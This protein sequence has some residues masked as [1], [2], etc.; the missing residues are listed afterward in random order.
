M[1]LVPPSWLFRVITSL[2]SLVLYQLRSLC[3]GSGNR[4]MCIIMKLDWLLLCSTWS[5]TEGC[6]SPVVGII[7]AGSSYCWKPLVE[8]YFNTASV[9][10]SFDFALQSASI[11][12]FPR[13]PMVRMIKS[14]EV[15][16]KLLQGLKSFP[17][18]LPVT[19]CLL[20]TRC[21][22]RWSI[23]IWD[24]GEN[25]VWINTLQWSVVNLPGII[26]LNKWVIAFTYSYRQSSISYFNLFCC[27]S[28]SCIW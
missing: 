2:W 25:L 14:R 13:V 22:I 4:V 10:N 1:L 18:S 6:S 19:A 20:Y 15:T 16:K 27:L 26:C 9:Q 24:I 17:S 12:R 23:Q 28:R 21:K 3:V 8:L 7:W 5:S 11:F